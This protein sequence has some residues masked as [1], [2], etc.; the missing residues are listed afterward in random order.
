[1]ANNKESD[2]EKNNDA[3]IPGENEQEGLSAEQAGEYSYNEADAWN[4]SKKSLILV[5]SA[6]LIG[7]SVYHYW[8][9]SERT[10][11]SE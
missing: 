10:H 7:V 2:P 8:D 6:I 11:Q 1:M 3:S 5:L 4:K 9:N